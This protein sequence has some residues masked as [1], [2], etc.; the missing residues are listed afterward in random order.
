[1]YK[2]FTDIIS[3]PHHPVAAMENW[4]LI[5]YRESMLW[6][7]D[8]LTSHLVDVATTLAHEISHMVS[9]YGGSKL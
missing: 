3:I 2:W 6:H 9:R 7:H 8:A 5:T 4:G 1:M